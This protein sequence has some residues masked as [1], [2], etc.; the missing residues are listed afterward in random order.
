MKKTQVLTFAGFALGIGMM[1]YGMGIPTLGLFLDIPSVAITLGGCIAVI[2]IITPGHVLKK[3]GVL[4]GQ[5]FK[6]STDSKSAV[7]AQFT[8]LSTK[9]RKEGLLSLED[10]INNLDDAFLKKGLQ[11][12]VDGIEP[13]S[14]KEIL[15]ADIA[16]METRHAENAN[17]FAMLGVYGPSMG[18]LGTL[19]GLIQMLANLTDA[20]TIAVG[21]GKALIT[22][23]YGSLIANLFGSPISQNLKAKSLIE[24]EMRAMML[25]GILAIQAGLNPRIVEEKLVCYLS[26]QEREMFASND[27]NANEGAA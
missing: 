25:D 2:M 4:V 16:G 21:M 7:I 27:S 17:M 3:F 9:A 19:I 12:V 14:I 15:E 10:A 13:D 24:V 5:A 1:F 6:E 8:E 22:T 18:M 23:Y 26:P 20:T 11:M